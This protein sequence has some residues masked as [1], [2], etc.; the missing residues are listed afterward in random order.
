MKTWFVADTHFDCPKLVQNTRSWTTVDDHDAL[1]LDAINSRVK[2]T[3][4]LIIC[5]DFCKGKPFKWRQL[6]ACRDVWLVLGNHDQGTAF[7]KCFGESR[8]KLAHMAKLDSGD[9]VYCSHYPHFAWPRSHY[10]TL[11]AFGHVHAQREDELDAM[12][13]ARRSIDVGVD[14]AVRLFGS[15]QPFEDTYLIETLGAKEGHG[16]VR[17][18]DKWKLRDFSGEDE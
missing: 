16:I 12:M 7:G 18:E 5:G 3:D 14:N 11:H 9:H 6:V 13:P 8:V 4:R 2:R 17:P 10:G 1:V 15:V